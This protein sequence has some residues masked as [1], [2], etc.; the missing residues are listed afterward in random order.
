[1]HK[2]PG[3]AKCIPARWGW[4]RCVH[5]FPPTVPVLVGSAPQGGQ[6]RL[7]R[8]GPKWEQRMGKHQLS[9]PGTR[10]ARPGLQQDLLSTSA[11]SCGVCSPGQTAAGQT[12]AGHTAARQDLA[13]PCCC[14]SSLASPQT[15]ST[16][17]GVCTELRPAGSGRTDPPLGGGLRGQ[18]GILPPHP[19]SPKGFRVM[20]YLAAS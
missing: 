8:D 10:R 1:M 7:S 15:V 20:W 9:P 14:H 19:S 4:G 12:A 17:M 5:P 2:N 18:E 6:S 13:V 3:N 11:L 16:P